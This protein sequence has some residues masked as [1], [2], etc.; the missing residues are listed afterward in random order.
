MPAQAK[1]ASTWRRTITATTTKASASSGTS[2][3]PFTPCS[4]SAPRPVIGTALFSS[5]SALVTVWPSDQ[6]Q[7]PSPAAP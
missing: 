3:A 5:R 2:I 6:I 1:A 7:C 4:A